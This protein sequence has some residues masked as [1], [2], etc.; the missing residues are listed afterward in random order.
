MDSHFS[1]VMLLSSVV[2]D[3]PQSK[4]HYKS[5]TVLWWNSVPPL[6]AIC[7]CHFS[8]WWSMYTRRTSSENTGKKQISNIGLQWPVIRFRSF[9]FSRVGPLRR[10][11][12]AP[13]LASYYFSS[14]NLAWDL[15]KEMHSGKIIFL[16]ICTGYPLYIGYFDKTNGNGKRYIVCHSSSSWARDMKFCHFS[17]WRSEAILGLAI[18]KVPVTRCIKTTLNV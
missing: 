15:V 11:I 13:L 8:R 17:R 12:M 10:C 14:Q 7:F 9:H 3:E 4:M 1:A 2:H 18:R 6:R 5:M 16:T